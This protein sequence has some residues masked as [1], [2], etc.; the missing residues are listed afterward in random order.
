[1]TVTRES[2]KVVFALFRVKHNNS[3]C[4]AILCLHWIVI[5]IACTTRS[6]VFQCP[7]LKNIKK[8]KKGKKKTTTFGQI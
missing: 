4:C 3:Q 6:E 2:M 8:K 1:M 5:S 7:G